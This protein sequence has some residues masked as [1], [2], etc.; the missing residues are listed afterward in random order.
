MSGLFSSPKTPRTPPP[1]PPEPPVAEPEKGEEAEADIQRRRIKA[2][3][4][5]T[6]LTGEQEPEKLGKKQVL[7]G[8]QIFS[9]NGTKTPRGVV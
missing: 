8:Y 3:R 4:G 6:I 9:R 7:G 1:P 5:G 2:G